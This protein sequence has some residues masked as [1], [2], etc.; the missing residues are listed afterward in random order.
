LKVSLRKTKEEA[1]LLEAIM[2]YYFSAGG[3]SGLVSPLFE[4]TLSDSEGGG[5]VFRIGGPFFPQEERR[6]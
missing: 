1:F 6:Q 5:D 3:F 4:S 2:C